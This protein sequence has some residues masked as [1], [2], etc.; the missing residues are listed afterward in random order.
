MT[1]LATKIATKQVERAAA[2]TIEDHLRAYE[3]EFQRALGQSMDAA[4]FAQDAL[5]AIKSNPKIGEADA[6]SL[7][8]ALFLAAQLRLP[9]GGPLAQFHLTLRNVKGKPTVVPIIGY[10]GYIQLATNTGLYS[11]VS[12]FLVRQNDYFMEGANSERGEFFDFKKATGDRGPV[13]GV[14]AYAKVKGFDESQHMYVDRDTVLD[15]HRPS[16]WKGTPWETNEDDQ[17][18]KTGIRVLQKWL[19]KTAE[20]VNLSL[21]ATADQAV[22]R[23]LDGVPDLQVQQDDT[24]P[25]DVID[26]EVVELDPAHPDYVASADER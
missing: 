21:A 18:Q 12:A 1:D 22:V 26:G 14:V 15:K 6:R 20:A 13:V 9:V 23:K 19:P 8:G 25:S 16:Y 11:K 10:N 24:P 7:F 17:I 4:K 2:P 3:P 5:T